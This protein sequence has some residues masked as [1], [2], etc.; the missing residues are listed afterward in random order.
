[1]TASHS[2]RSS[3][4]LSSSW[5]SA[6]ARLVGSMRSKGSWASPSTGPPVLK[7]Q[8]QG[9]AVYWPPSF[10]V[11]NGEPGGPVLQ[12]VPLAYLRSPEQKSL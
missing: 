8:G 12:G 1:M 7:W 6:A 10:E 5:R 3:L 11:R 9:V 4:Q 2:T